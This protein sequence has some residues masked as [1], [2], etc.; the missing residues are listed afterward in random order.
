MEKE[1]L[2]KASRA[3]SCSNVVIN[4]GDIAKREVKASIWV[5]FAMSS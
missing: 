2:C 4:D 5:G 3:S 1:Q